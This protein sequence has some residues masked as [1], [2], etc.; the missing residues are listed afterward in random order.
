MMITSLPSSQLLME[1]LSKVVIG[2]LSGCSL[3]LFLVFLIILIQERRCISY[4]SILGQ[5]VS[6]VFY[7]VCLTITGAV[8]GLV[9]WIG[10]VRVICALVVMAVFIF[11]AFFMYGGEQQQNSKLQSSNTKKKDNL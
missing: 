5:F 2:A 4:D 10:F 1:I 6:L 9:Q 7:P 8:L 11:G 3:G